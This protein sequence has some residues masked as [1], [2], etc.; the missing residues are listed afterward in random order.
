MDKSAYWR[1]GTQ[2]H[3]RFLSGSAFVK[4][5]IKYFAQIWEHHANI[6]F[7]FDDSPTA[8]IRISF[9]QGG[10]SWPYLGRHNLQIASDKPTMNFGWFY[11][12]TT[13]EEFSRTTIHK[14]GHALGCIH[15]HMSPAAQIPWDKDRV[16]A[17][18]MGAPNHWTKEDVDANLFNKYKASRAYYTT[19]D[20]LSIM[21]YRI[22]ND[23]TIGD[24]ETPK[25]GSL[26]N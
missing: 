21:L 20:P 17:Y 13:D 4:D 11:D 16:Y 25:N 1:P 8:Q 26:T 3:V 14:F 19:F 2:L 5:K 23:L 12:N 6:V 24:F 22:S 9:V 18:F 15:E 7:V 10:G